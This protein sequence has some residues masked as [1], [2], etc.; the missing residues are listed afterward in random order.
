LDARDHDHGFTAR[1]LVREISQFLI[2][3]WGIAEVEFQERISFS[4]FSGP[5]YWI[6]SFF[7][8]YICSCFKCSENDR[9]KIKASGSDDGKFYPA[10]IRVASFNVGCDYN[11]YTV[12]FIIITALE[13][14]KIQR[15]HKMQMQFIEILIIV[16]SLG[17]NQ[18]IKM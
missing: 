12:S 16:N 18:P 7:L 13:C 8:F 3:Q 15:S 2:G 14:K 5:P 9:K 6:F 17:K 10:I 4:T 11:K 1:H